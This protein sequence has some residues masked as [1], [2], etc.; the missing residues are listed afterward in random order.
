MQNVLVITS[1]ENLINFIIHDKV[2]SLV[3]YT[4]YADVFRGLRMLT[5]KYFDILIFDI[6]SPSV[7]A[8]HALN[9]AKT[10]QDELHIIV[11]TNNA[12][13][14]RQKK[15]EKQIIDHLLFKPIQYEHLSKHLKFVAMNR[16][17][18]KHIQLNNQHAINNQ[19]AGYLKSQNKDV[20]VK[21]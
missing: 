5:Y 6:D 20:K 14:L 11:I 9:I 13:I 17:R 7:D 2:S 4:H 15:L 3:R 12:H 18:K 10:I 1:D 8:V 21:K 16:E 19:F